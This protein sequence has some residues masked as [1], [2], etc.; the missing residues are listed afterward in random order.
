MLASDRMQGETVGPSERVLNRVARHQRLWFSF[1]GNMMLS[2]S[3][4][5]AADNATIEEDGNDLDMVAINLASGAV[6][7]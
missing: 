2:G 6:C 1:L 3:K 7:G 4:H 5:P